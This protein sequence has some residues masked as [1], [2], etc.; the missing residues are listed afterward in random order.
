MAT[1]VGTQRDVIGLLHALIELDYDAIEAY[2]VANARLSRAALREKFSLFLDDHQRHVKELSDLVHRMG[3]EPPAGADLKQILTKGKI[4]LGDLVGGDRAILLAM[5]SNEDDTNTAYER[6]TGRRDLPGDVK[7]IA[8]RNLADERTHRAWIEQQLVVLE[9]EESAE[10]RAFDD[11]S[12]T[13][14]CL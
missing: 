11:F 1:L 10:T 3:A 13:D 7:L 2:R 9:E 8:E 6:V 14:M 12:D 5:Q 4:V